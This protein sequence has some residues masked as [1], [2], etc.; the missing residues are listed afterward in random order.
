MLFGPL[1][2]S[3]IETL[4][5]GKT[6]GSFEKRRGFAIAGSVFRLLM[7]FVHA[8]FRGLFGHGHAENWYRLGGG[9]PNHTGEAEDAEQGILDN[10]FHNA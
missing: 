10:G 1:L 9:G 3:D 2:F 8:E 7:D 4:P 5:A 6:G